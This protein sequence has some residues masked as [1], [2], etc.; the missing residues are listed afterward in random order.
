MDQEMSAHFAPIARIVARYISGALIGYGV[1]SP[2]DAEILS[3]EIVLIVGS[4][5]SIITEAIYT[6]AVKK[7]WAK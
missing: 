1:I 7:G 6:V 4:V 2:A 3:P 5:L